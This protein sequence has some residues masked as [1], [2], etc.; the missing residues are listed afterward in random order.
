MEKKSAVDSDDDVPVFPEG[1]T[2]KA[3][4]D[5]DDDVLLGI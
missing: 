4:R 5:P 2:S 1:W 3:K